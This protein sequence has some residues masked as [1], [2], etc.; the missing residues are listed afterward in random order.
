MRLRK[1]MFSAGLL[2]GTAMMLSGCAAVGAIPVL[3]DLI[4][5]ELL[6]E[7]LPSE[8][9]E[10]TTSLKKEAAKEEASEEGI[11]KDAEKDWGTEQETG[12][13]GT[14]FGSESRNMKILSFLVPAG[15]NCQEADGIAIL[16]MPPSPE[17]CE[18]FRAVNRKYGASEKE[19][20]QMLSMPVQYMT[21]E[22]DAGKALKWFYDKDLE[23]AEQAAEA[24]LHD[25]LV[26]GYEQSKEPGPGRCGRSAGTLAGQTMY[27]VHHTGSHEAVSWQKSYECFLDGPTGT[28]IRIRYNI[29]DAATEQSVREVMDSIRFLADFEAAAPAAGVE[30]NTYTMSFT[31]TEGYQLREVL[32][33]S[34]WISE[35]D[36]ELL[37]TA[38]DEISRGKLFPSQTSLNL[39][40]DRIMTNG[41]WYIN[42][43]EVVYAVGTFDVYNDTPGFDITAEDTRSFTIPLYG[44]RKYMSMRMFFS[45]EEKLY[46]CVPQEDGGMFGTKGGG[47][48]PINGLMKANHWGPVPFVIALVLDKTPDHPAGNPTPEECGFRFGD[49]SFTLPVTW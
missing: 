30:W 27:V 32:K 48:N 21:I 13:E 18:T 43:D 9:D 10:T 19:I 4:L 6:P 16:T 3:R 5:E 47:W 24:C 8:T 33:I 25:Y 37:K 17:Y 28:I 46:Y 34:P 31:D 45:K 29:C 15:S 38:W 7:I 49:S 40:G 39:L 23:T 36:P 20:D 11:T 41:K 12:T 14:G 26:T 2:L 22:E 1:Y 35:N 42:Y 44:A